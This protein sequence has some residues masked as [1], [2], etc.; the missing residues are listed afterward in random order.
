MHVAW[1]SIYTRGTKFHIKQK[2]NIGDTF[3]VEINPKQLL[4]NKEYS[5][6]SSN[7]TFIEKKLP[8]LNVQRTGFVY[9][10]ISYKYANHTNHF[11]KGFKNVFVKSLGNNKEIKCAL[12]FAQCK[13]FRAKGKFRRIWATVA[14]WRITSWPVYT[15]VAFVKAFL[16]FVKL[17]AP[18]IYFDL[19]AYSHVPP[20]LKLGIVSLSL[21]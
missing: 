2:S 17:L 6:P 19:K 11:Q 20:Q 15:T 3:S 16:P 10:I 1:C 12:Y 21:V 9:F 18:S 4:Y 13:A 5:F 14:L 7:S 8:F